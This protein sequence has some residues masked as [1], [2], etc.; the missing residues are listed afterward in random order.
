MDADEIQKRQAK[1]QYAFGQHELWVEDCTTGHR[2]STAEI[3]ELMD[4]YGGLAITARNLRK[5]DL[6]GIQARLSGYIADLSYAD[7]TDAKISESYLLDANLHSAILKNADLTDAWLGGANL[8]KADLMGANLTGAALTGANLSYANLSGVTGL[9]S[10]SSFMEQFVKDN[11][12]WYVYKHIA[13]PNNP[14]QRTSYAAPPH[15]DIKPGSFLTETVNPDRA[16]ECGSGINFG[17]KA[18]VR[19]NYISSDL[20][21]CRIWFE[22]GPDIIVPYTT[23]GKARCGRLELIK[24]V[25]IASLR[26]SPPTQQ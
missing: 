19:R 5:A 6:S 10:A 4:D 25:D 26:Y 1:M 9:P 16:T 21:L 24:L 12:G 23:E 15:W 18:W 14:G 13:N 20:W 22:D 8:S 11:V 7:L 17:T 3:P 2:L